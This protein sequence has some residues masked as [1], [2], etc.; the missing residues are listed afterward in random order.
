ML[1]FKT[2]KILSRFYVKSP[3]IIKAD[4]KI[5]ITDQEKSLF[6]TLL[7]HLSES[8]VRVAGGWVRDK[9]LGLTSDDIDITLNNM[10][11]LEAAEKLKQ[12]IS[13][14]SSIGKM[15]E[16][17]E[18]SKHLE[19]ACI[20]ILGY[21][22]DLANLRTESYSNSRIPQ[23]VIFSQCFGSPSEDAHRRDLTINSLFFNVSQ[24]TIEDWTG[25]GLQDLESRIARTPLEP[26][27]TMKD[28][29]LRV[30]RII[31]FTSR[32]RLGLEKDLDRVLRDKRIHEW[33]L[34][35]VSRERIRIEFEKMIENQMFFEAIRLLEDFE[36]FSVVFMIKDFKVKG[37]CE[38]VQSLGEK[39]RF[40]KYVTAVLHYFAPQTIWFNK[41]EVDI[42]SYV[43]KDSLKLSKK[44]EKIIK[45]YLDCLPELEKLS[46][47]FC[48]AEAG[49]IIKELSG[50]WQEILDLL[51][52]DSS[53]SLLS[54]IHLHNLEL[55][56]Q[57]SILFRVN[58]IR[59]M[60]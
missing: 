6:S 43:C 17:P 36:L 29:P 11:G 42:S 32:F 2:Q 9:L 14:S 21:S 13:N 58:L 31:R 54:N 26:E 53:K 57:E 30:L 27:V 59:A 38:K 40:E 35:K 15:K 5:S 34:K 16:N 52:L 45:K 60:S 33:I 48:P 41:K 37:S 7:K 46:E 20:R 47:K 49:R 22:L 25:F 19:T 10:T 55:F 12:N 50:D 56:W 23:M 18:A 44:Q 3:I 24:N 1:A 51:P 28:D 4:S 39:Y 8:E